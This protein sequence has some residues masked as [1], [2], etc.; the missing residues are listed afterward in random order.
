MGI[1]LALKKI[2]KTFTA[3]GYSTLSWYSKKNATG[4]DL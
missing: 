1:F 3:F 2:F 4:N